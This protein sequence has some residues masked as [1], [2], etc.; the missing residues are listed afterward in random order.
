MT[1]RPRSISCPG[2]MSQL[3]DDA[4]R[5]AAAWIMFSLHRALTC[6][7]VGRR[8]RPQRGA[9]SVG[10][11]AL[12]QPWDRDRNDRRVGVLGLRLRTRCRLRVGPRRRVRSLLA[13]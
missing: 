13:L 7:L 9:L 6:A 5:E 4:A 8:R 2:R 12:L 3:S 10:T 11:S 1:A